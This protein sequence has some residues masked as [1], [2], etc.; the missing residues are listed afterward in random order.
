MRESA[1]QGVFG[2]A[3]FEVGRAWARC[4]KSLRSTPPW[5]ALRAPVCPHPD[6]PP[7]RGGGRQ[8]ERPLLPFRVLGGERI[9]ASTSSPLA[10]EGWDRGERSGLRSVRLVSM[11]RLRC[12]RVCDASAGSR[13]PAG[14]TPAL[15]RCAEEGANRC[16]RFCP[17]PRSRGK[18]GMGVSGA[19][20]VP[21]ALCQ[22]A[23]FAAFEF[24]MRPLGRGLRRALPR[25]SP[26]ARR[27][28]KSALAY[29]IR[30]I[31]ADLPA[32]VSGWSSATLLPVMTSRP[33]LAAWMKVPKRSSASGLVSAFRFKATMTVS[34]PS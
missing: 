14:P 30:M 24:A 4:W 29:S 11:R 18:V 27:R 26:A 16:A 6:P 33:L 15:P 23:G 28:G 22:C 31:V 20:Y 17:F 3:R 1:L 9:G 5:V 12:V 10:G 21:F 34:S 7:L 32:S 25:P 13:T 8:S 2:S 19:A